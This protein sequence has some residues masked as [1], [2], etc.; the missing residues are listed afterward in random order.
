MMKNCTEKQL[1]ANC[2][3]CYRNEK[4]A[5]SAPV[6]MAEPDF[7][8]YIGVSRRNP[9]QR[10]HIGRDTAIITLVIVA[11]VMFVANIIISVYVRL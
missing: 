11:I 7:D 2:V 5:S 8:E 6:S 9:R 1:K 4:I 3:C 10:R